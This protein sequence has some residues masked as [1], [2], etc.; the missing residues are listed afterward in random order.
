MTLDERKKK[1]PVD[2]GTEDSK[3]SDYVE[4]SDEEDVEKL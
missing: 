1:K 4:K 3:A 2:W